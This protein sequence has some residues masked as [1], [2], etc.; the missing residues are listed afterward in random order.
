MMISGTIITLNEEANIAD[1]IRSLQQ[2]CDEVVVADSQ[3]QDR[4]VAIAEEL[5]AKVVVQPYLG[6]GP[7]KAFAAQQASHDWVLSVDADE[8]LDDDMVEAIRA[9]DLANTECD[10]FAFNRKTFIGKTWIRVWYP[11]YVIRLYNRKTAAYEPIKGH[12][13]VQ[14]ERIQRINA[15][16]I[17]Y[18]FDD[19][20]EL[21]RQNARFSARGAS[22]LLDKNKRIG[23]LSPLIHALSAFF[24]KY[25]SKKGFLY[26][27]PGFTV[28]LATAYGTYMKYVM[29]RRKQRDRAKRD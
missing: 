16:L 27:E 13:K 26:G 20:H 22:I 2:V 7:Q 11:D 10:A 25:V 9:L 6:D 12:A 19:Y 3:S 17:H 29:A 1:C 4:T 28:S 5:G 23:A 8:R 18:S 21:M 24:R 15:H 14:A